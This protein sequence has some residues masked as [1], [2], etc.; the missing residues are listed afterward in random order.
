MLKR[1]VIAGGCAIALAGCTTDRPEDVISRY[2]YA[3]AVPPTRN[4]GLGNLVYK[5]TNPSNSENEITLG[6]ICSP[7]YVRFPGDPEK[8][9]SETV[10]SA[11][12]KTF[13]FNAGFL[14][15]L[16][17]TLSAKYV[18]SFTMSFKNTEVQE[19]ALDKLSDI[20]DTLGPKCAD[21]LAA[22]KRKN[23][24]YQVVSAFKADL[25]YKI[26]YSAN[27]SADVKPAVMQELSAEFGI[28]ISGER[29]RVGKDL[30]YGVYVE[31]AG[32]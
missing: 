24:A 21:I 6:Y 3:V 9:T 12:N 22:M 28:D 20:R 23:N 26:D 5:R 13:S 11:M 10:A 14:Q 8:S 2:G 7:E 16:G 4:Y 15:Q 17:L 1:L 19:Y 27:V 32:G 18:D 31:P 30:F 29:G 25:D